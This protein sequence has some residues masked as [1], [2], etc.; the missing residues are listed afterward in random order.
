MKEIHRACRDAFPIQL[1]QIGFSRARGCSGPCND[2]LK[3][4]GI[5]LATKEI[6][7]IGTDDVTHLP[8][9]G[10]VGHYWPALSVTARTWI[11]LALAVPVVLWAGWP[12]F[13]RCVAS[14]RNRS[15]NMFTLIGIGVAAAFGISEE[16]GVGKEGVSECRFRWA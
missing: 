4:G 10:N 14:I 1:A 11:E 7:P 2:A 3:S 16:S 12:F 5:Q 6:E 8:K 9:N 15:P 13:E